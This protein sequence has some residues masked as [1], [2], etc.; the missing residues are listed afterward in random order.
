MAPQL[1]AALTPKRHNSNNAGQNKSTGHGCQNCIGQRCCCSTW[2][3]C[4]KYSPAVASKPSNM[5][6]S[7]ACCAALK[8]SALTKTAPSHARLTS[9]NASGKI[10]KLSNGIASRFVHTCIRL[11]GK[12]QNHSSGSMVTNTTHCAST[13]ACNRPLV[14][15]L[16]KASNDNTAIKEKP[17]PARVQINGFSNSTNSSARLSALSQFSRQPLKNSHSSTIIMIQARCSAI[18]VPASQT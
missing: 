2:S 3:N 10:S 17:K 14:R 6:T 16:K 1:S 15:P 4:Q 5:P 7:A 9:S 12:P 13:N 11:T 8:T 18:P